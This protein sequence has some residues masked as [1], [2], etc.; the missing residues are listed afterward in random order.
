M[1]TESVLLGVTGSTCSVD[2]RA[3]LV[4][5]P[6]AGQVAQRAGMMMRTLPVTVTSPSWQVTRLPVGAGQVPL[7]TGSSS[8]PGSGPV[9]CQVIAPVISSPAGRVSVIT[10]PV[11]FSGPVPLRSRERLAPGPLLVP[12]ST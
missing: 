10:V 9:F 7:P 2:T 3:V 8:P 1:T 11:P 6:P 5:L 12:S 4:A